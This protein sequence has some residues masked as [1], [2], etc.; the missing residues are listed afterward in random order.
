MVH[1]GLSDL[2]ITIFQIEWQ[3][4]DWSNIM[5]ILIL[6]NYVQHVMPNTL[7]ANAYRTHLTSATGYYHHLLCRLQSEVD[8]NLEG[9]IDFYYLPDSKTREFLI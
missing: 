4:Y 1:N 5:Y 2:L 3:N 7:L 6:L 9:I 8:L